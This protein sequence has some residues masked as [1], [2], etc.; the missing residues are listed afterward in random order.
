MSAE[1]A[2]LE[3]KMIEWDRKERAAK[4]EYEEEERRRRQ[5][6]EQQRLQQPGFWG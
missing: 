4:R 6:E 3:R 1:D 2:E 5:H